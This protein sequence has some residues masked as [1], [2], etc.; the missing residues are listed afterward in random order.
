V[1]ARFI[2]VAFSISGP[3]PI[4]ALKKVFDTALDWI[5]YDDRCWI[6]YTN[7]EI[8]TWRDRIRKTPG[9]KVT[10]GFFLCEFE[11]KYSGY[12]DKWVWDWLQKD[13]SK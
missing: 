3:V 9:I 12:M 2:H 13:R 1:T 8:D 7:T 4:D 11:G 10:D 6:L 5:R